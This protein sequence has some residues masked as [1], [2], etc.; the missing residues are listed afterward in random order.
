MDCIL[1]GY[2]HR[3]Q[4]GH[5]YKFG[6]SLILGG[7]QGLTGA[8]IMAAQSAQAT[9]V[10][11]VTAA[12][13]QLNYGELVTRISPD[14]LTGM[15]PRGNEQLA[16][17]LDSLDKYNSIVIGPG[18]GRTEGA[19]NIVLEV[20]NNCAHPVILD[21]DALMVLSYKGDKQILKSRKSPTI[22]T[23]HYAEF[24][25]FIDVEWEE[26]KRN[27]LKYMKKFVDQTN[28]ALI[29]KGPCTYIAFPNGMLAVNYAPNSGLAKGGSGDVLAGILGGIIA[30]LD[31]EYSWDFTSK[32]SFKDQ[33]L[34]D[35]VCLG[36]FLHSQAGEYAA[37]E[38]GERGMLAS[39]LKNYLRPV[40]D[41]IEAGLNR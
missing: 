25:R 18:L 23:P 22:L 7:S 15:L 4:F 10:G 26:V 27:P 39:Q 19:R 8:L 28:A 29:L 12:T 35:A 1:N 37:Q 16:S 38:L 36:V 31:R 34:L 3:D 17:S 6:H 9:G 5:K 33:E 40:F 11:V 24:A 41:T 14:I 30:Q 21:A 13:W 2:R 32:L 20:L